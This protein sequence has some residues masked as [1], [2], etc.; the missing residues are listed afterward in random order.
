MNVGATLL[1]GEGLASLLLI[2]DSDRTRAELRGI[3]DASGLFSEIFEADDGVKGLRLILEKSV[4][5]VICRLE[6]SGLDGTKLLP[7]IRSHHSSAAIPLV[8]TT[9]QD[10]PARR[11]RI[12]EAGANDA[13]TL[14][15]HEGEL[16]ARLKLHLRQKQL[17][18]DLRVK[19]DTLGR[20]STLDSLTGLRTRRFV[21]DF[22]SIEFLRARRYE[23]PLTVMLGDLDHFKRVNDDHGH[24]TGDAVL[25]GVSTLLLHDLRATDIAGRYGGEEILVVLPQ[26]EISGARIFA[27]RWREA[28]AESAFASPEGTSVAATISIGLACY[29]SEMTSPEALVGAA[30]AALY[31]AKSKGRNRTELAGPGA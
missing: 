29:N 31:R 1:E 26:G 4:D 23:N 9:S 22:L 5:I 19:N 8:F 11:A 27:E 6:L 21:D 24:L 30:D 3:I 25:R 15:V 13:I 20:L 14:P 16:I 10:D 17:Q 12:L 7:A 2:D 18:D 28:V